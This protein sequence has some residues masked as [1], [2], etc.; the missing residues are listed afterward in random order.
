MKGLP[1]EDWSTTRDTYPGQTREPVRELTQSWLDFKLA[2]IFDF[3][4]EP[5]DDDS[6]LKEVPLCH[7]S[8]RRAI[9]YQTTSQIVYP[10]CGVK[11]QGHSSD[12]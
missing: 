8:G 9:C 11:T 1:H 5:A 4:S 2:R 10:R 12:V 3:E 6:D 7:S